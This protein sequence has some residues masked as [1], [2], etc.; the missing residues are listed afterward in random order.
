MNRRRQPQGPTHDFEAIPPLLRAI[1]RA[2][3]MRSAR[4]DGEIRAIS[5]QPRFFATT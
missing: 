3:N 4:N 2:K 5:D 1:G